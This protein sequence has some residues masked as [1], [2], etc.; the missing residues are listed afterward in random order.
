MLRGVFCS[1]VFPPFGFFWKAAG[2]ARRWVI[3]HQGAS[4]GQGGRL[5]RGKEHRGQ[6][7]VS[8]KCPRRQQQ[9]AGGP[10]GSG[11]ACSFPA[12]KKGIFSF[13][14]LEGNNPQCAEGC[15]TGWASKYRDRQGGRGNVVGG[16][17]KSKHLNLIFIIT[18][19]IN[20]IFSPYYHYYTVIIITVTHPRVTRVCFSPPPHVQTHGWG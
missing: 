19:I 16:R 20:N 6:Q 12:L 14:Y 4:A 18:I 1:T 9:L 17:A 3:H 5:P 7:R 15:D 11:R 13:N 8:A 10:R 2:A